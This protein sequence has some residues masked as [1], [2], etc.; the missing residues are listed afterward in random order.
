M[1]SLREVR[2]ALLLSH[3]SGVVDDEEFLFLYDINQSKNDYCYWAYDKFDLET[4]NDAETWSEFRFLKNNLFRLK[5]ALKLPNYFKTYNRLKVS[6]IEGLCIMLRRLAYPCRYSEFIPRFGRPVPDYCIIFYDIMNQVYDRFNYL[7]ADFNLPFLSRPHL[8]AYCQ[9]INNKG[10]AL[11][12][13]FGFID[14][15]VRPICR[16]GQDQQIVYNGH[17]KV[18]SLKFQSVVLP[19][20][21]I[22]NM[23]GPLEGKRH[24][25]ALLR[26]LNLLTTKSVR[27]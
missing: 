18:H 22:A 1:A 6:G 5:D 17:K 9:A 16:P 13:C 23:F 7:L 8:T 15:T 2:D 27:I 10:A 20:G 21:L 25:C 14:G 24:D 11:D 12:N 19:N 4:M 26:E 3:D